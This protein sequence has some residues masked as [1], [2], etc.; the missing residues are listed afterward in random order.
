V[1]EDT[2]ISDIGLDDIKDLAPYRLHLRDAPA[3][4][5]TRELQ[6][7]R[8]QPDGNRSGRAFEGKRDRPNAYRTVSRFAAGGARCSSA[9][10]CAASLTAMTRGLYIRLLAAVLDDRTAR[11]A[12]PS[13]QEKGR[14]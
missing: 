8:P 10:S 9:L 7:L 1:L 5:R 11:W 13:E 12:G 14:S 3:Q 2:H 6:V 4:A